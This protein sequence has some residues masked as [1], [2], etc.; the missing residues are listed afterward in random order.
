MSPAWQYENRLTVKRD[1]SDDCF[2]DMKHK[3]FVKK[4]NKNYEDGVTF[5]WKGGYDHNNAVKAEM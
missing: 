5:G 3:D 1:K 4:V 2:K